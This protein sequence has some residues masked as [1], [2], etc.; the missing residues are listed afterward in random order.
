[1]S[2]GDTNKRNLAC[3]YLQVNVF[4]C[5]SVPGA[6]TTSPTSTSTA[7]GTTMKTTTKTTT[8]S[9]ASITPK[10]CRWNSS[11]GQYDYP[12]VWPA[13]PGPTQ[14]GIMYDCIKWML[15]KS[16]SYCSDM[17]KAAGITLEK[18]YLLNPAVGMNCGGLWPGT[19]NKI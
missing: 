2:A 13:A 19:P 15:Q 11:K 12:G 5:V 14:E 17:A 3:R 1:M 4:V 7:M 9:P 8:S 18:L 10:P 16:G 6:S